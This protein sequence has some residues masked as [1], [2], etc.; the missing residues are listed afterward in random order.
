M[1]VGAGPAGVTAAL[2]LAADGYRV[3]VLERRGHPAEMEADKK[4][5]YL[6]GLGER[7]LRA[8]DGVGLTVPLHVG[9]PMRGSVYAYKSGKRVED[10][11]T[12]DTRIVGVDRQGL[13]AFLVNEASARHPQGITF[14]W[15]AQPAAFDLQAKTLTCQVG[16][17]STHT[18]TGSGPLELRYDLLIG[19]DGSGSAVRDALAAALPDFKVQQL[20]SP[21]AEMEYKAFH[22]LPWND[23]IRQLLPSYAAGLGAHAANGAAAAAGTAG[24]ADPGMTFFAFNNPQPNQPSPGSITLY[25]NAGGTW[26][27]TLYQPPGKFEAMAGDVAGH[28]AAVTMFAP[29]GFPDS[30][31]PL[32][33]QQMAS[34]KPSRISPMN[35]VSQLAAPSLG[36]V[37]LGDA[38]HNVTPQMGQGCNSALEDGK[39]L[40]AALQQS[41]HDVAAGLSRFEQQRLPQVHAL[42]R[43]EEEN[44]WVRR[45]PQ[46]FKDPLPKTLARVA[47]ISFF[48]LLPLLRLLPGM[49]RAVHASLFQTIMSTTIPYNRLQTLIRLAPFVWAGLIAVLVA[50]GKQMLRVGMAMLS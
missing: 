15:H 13:A 1:V 40:A 30:W 29:P 4:R 20:T 43:M 19:A 42:Q 48:M 39:L 38:G 33:A 25:L 28:E 26:S 17:S 18:G 21:V 23:G 41:G 11:F 44:S 2:Y 16:S 12:P 46:L 3:H 27:G 6:I 49:K 31:V 32:M 10:P 50:G 14:H 47:W 8:L 35:L 9:R 7:G 36:V 34:I 24:S 37:L 5:T 22:N 45:P